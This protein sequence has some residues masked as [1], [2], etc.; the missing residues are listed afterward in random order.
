VS[1]HGRLWQILLL[2]VSVI[3]FGTAGYQLIEGW[4]FFDAL[5]MTMIT[6]ASVGFGEVHPLSTAGRTFTIAL[7]A[8]G[9]GV[10][11]YGLGTITAFWVEG[12]LLHLW[13]KRRMERRIAALKDHIVVC[14]GGETGRHVARELL[15]IRRP[16]VC[17]EIDPAAEEALVK[18]GQGI[19]YI[20]GDATSS[21][22]LRRAGVEVAAGL[23]A[24]MPADKDNLF[25]LLSAR[26]LN[27]TM[28]IVSRA[29]LDDA[30]PKLLKAGADVVVSVPT[31]GALRLASAMVRPNVV[32]FLDAMLREPGA[33]RVHEVTVGPAR[34][35]QTLAALRLQERTGV[36]VFGLRESATHR[37]V[38]N[39]PP[40]R[41]LQA[42]DVL[43]GCA[44][45][46]Q[47]AALQRMVTEG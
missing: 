42:G 4:A 43:I 18:L 31:I 38:F 19:L 12:D 20:V 46:D 9:L 44:D 45:P 29:V 23:V 24:C 32:S 15:Q 16:F 11:A 22:V 39:P 35:G 41:P 3:S 26:E 34:A 37:H 10:V 21:D 47:A 2:L 36:V 33:V 6:V 25:A 14:G 13:E 30:G 28:R 5:Y 17:I 40:E 27:P 1:P 7:I 8:V